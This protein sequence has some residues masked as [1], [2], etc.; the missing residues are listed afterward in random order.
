VELGALVALRPPERRPALARAELPKV[1]GRLGDG[2]GEELD[3]DPAQWLAWKGVREG[4]RR[5]GG[6]WD[7]EGD[8]SCHVTGGLSKGKGDIP[9]TVISRKT[10]V[11]LA[12]HREA[13]GYREGYRG[14]PDSGSCVGMLSCKCA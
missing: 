13:V 9:P 6:V 11:V 7:E 8:G 3:L 5:V 12:E 10:L 1:L 2:V 14:F 4:A